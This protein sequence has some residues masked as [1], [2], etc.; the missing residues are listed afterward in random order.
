MQRNRTRLSLLAAGAAGLLVAGGTGAASAV[1]EAP[2]QKAS[3]Q[4]DFNGDG[5]ADLA[6]SGTRGTVSGL[7]DAGYAAV[8]YGGPHGLSTASRTIISRATA[9]IPGDPE[10]GVGFGYALSHGDLDG[11]GYA[12]LVISNRGGGEDSVIVW[13]SANGLSG[14]TAVPHYGSLSQTGDFNGDGRTDLALFDTIHIGMDDPSGT[15]AVVWNGPISRAG[16]PASTTATDAASATEI[17]TAVSGDVNHDGYADL[18]IGAYSGEGSDN[19]YLVYGS[20]SGLSAHASDERP[21]GANGTAALGDV[22]GDGYDDFVAGDT[23]NNVVVAYGAA[24]GLSSRTSTINQNTAGVPGASEGEDGFG[25]SVAVGDVTGDGI[26]DVAVGAPGEAIGTIEGTGAVTV[27]KGSK[28][29]LTGT[30]SQSFSQDTAGVPGAAEKGDAFGSA[31]HLVDINGN[32]YADLAASATYED[33]KNGA[34]WLLRGRP[35]GLTTDAALLFGPKA[36][37]AP[38]TAAWFG[39]VL[40]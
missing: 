26:D 33:A 37:G 40:G 12:D 31:V 14:G 25:E 6:I 22:N 4:D 13:G 38:A 16:K 2:V 30:G 7:A 23:N 34:V 18:A 1:T 19:T 20:A 32:G 3:V 36:L 29:G 21:P 11:D 8:T 27:L 39:Y 35:E 17:T 5:Y 9:G 10:T 24:S 15:R 28:G